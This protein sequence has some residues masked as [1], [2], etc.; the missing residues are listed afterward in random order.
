MQIK[1]LIELLYE[2]LKSE[3]ITAEHGVLLGKQI[4]LLAQWLCS[5]LC[6]YSN[7]F[8]LSEE[9][10]S[11]SKEMVI[12]VSNLFLVLFTN[13]T[14]Y[15]LW[16]MIIKAQK[17][18][19]HWKHIREQVLKQIQTKE[20][21]IQ[22]DVYE[23]IL[24]KYETFLSFSFSIS[25][26]FRI[27]R[28]HLSEEFHHEDIEFNVSIFNPTVSTL[29]INQ[30]H[31]SSSIL[32]VMLRFYEYVSSNSNP[33]SIYLRLLQSS[34]GGY[35]ASVSTNNSEYQQRWSAFVHF[36]LPRI[37]ASCFPSQF[38]TIKQAIET[39]LLHNEYLLNRLDELCVENIFERVFRTTLNYVAE[40]IKIKYQ[41]E[42]EHLNFYIQQI[43]RH[44]IQQIQQHYQSQPTRS[45]F[46]KQTKILQITVSLLI[47]LFR[48]IYLRN[49]SISNVL[50]KK[51]N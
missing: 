46:S 14:L 31:R 40:E 50:R 13:P 49:S 37:L 19:N 33:S 10:S 12:S 44:F 42:I 30:L 20:S 15:C 26:L 45:S 34:F 41:T 48:F 24:F 21:S 4:N 11:K 43:R 18:Q 8:D 23:Q 32:L 3:H 25:T 28:L 22:S 51:S 1:F 39:F 47:F 27:T 29:V 36:Q 17:E 2:I 38:H 6:V 9:S 7:Q 35:A 5:A 16:L